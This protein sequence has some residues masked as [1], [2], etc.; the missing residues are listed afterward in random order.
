MKPDR[1]SARLDVF[2]QLDDARIRAGP[3]H[4]VDLRNQ[5][6]QLGAV[7]LREAAGD[8][9]LLTATLAR[10]MLE[11]DFGGFFLCRIDEGARVDDDRIRASGLRFQPPAGAREF[12]DHHLGVH[13]VLRTTE[14]DECDASHRARF[15]NGSSRTA[16]AARTPSLS[17]T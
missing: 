17:V 16:R 15:A 9:Q 6:L 7:A 4:A 5:A 10:G 14:A 8:D 1:S 12:S 2:E 13:E 3:D 11:D